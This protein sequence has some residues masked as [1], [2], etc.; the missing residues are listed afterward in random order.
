[1]S[2]Y[3]HTNIA[4]TV[5]VYLKL[6]IKCNLKT[7]WLNDKVYKTVGELKN[8]MLVLIFLAALLIHFINS[9]KKKIQNLFD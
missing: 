9:I 8:K 6:N 3:A 7:V 4:N 5:Q 2:L 1:M